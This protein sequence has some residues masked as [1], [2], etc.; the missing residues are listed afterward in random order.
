M[1]NNT[2]IEWTDEQMTLLIKERKNKKDEYFTAGRSKVKFW[3]DIA[4]IINNQFNTEF[5][6]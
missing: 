6:E 4:T 5:S 3:I 2:I 1:T